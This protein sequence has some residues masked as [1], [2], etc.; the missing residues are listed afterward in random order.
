MPYRSIKLPAVPG[1]VS[2]DEVEEAARA[3][4]APGIPPVS[5]LRSEYTGG[6]RHVRI[7]SAKKPTAKSA[8]AKK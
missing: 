5:P 3:L 2:V 6:H 4:R 1:N 8:A 7:G